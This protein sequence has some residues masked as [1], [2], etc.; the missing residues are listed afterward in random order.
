MRH[1]HRTI[2]LFAVVLL[3][4]AGIIQA[5]AV[6]NEEG[7]PLP[8][9]VAGYWGAA[10][11]NHLRW[12]TIMARAFSTTDSIWLNGHLVNEASGRIHFHLRGPIIARLTDA[13][14]TEV[15]ASLTLPD[16][17]PYLAVDATPVP[18]AD[19]CTFRVDLRAVF[20]KL[21]PGTYTF[22]MTI[23]AAGYTMEG[24]E[25]YAPAE[26]VSAVVTFDV[27]AI[28]LEELARKFG[29]AYLM[30][31]RLDAPDAFAAGKQHM[32]IFTNNMT[33]DVLVPYTREEKAADG[34]PF[35]VADLT[36]D[37]C[38]VCSELVP[39]DWY[40][41]PIAHPTALY[42]AVSPGGT[43]RLL[44]PDWQINGDGAYKYELR[45]YSPTKDDTENK[46]P[47]YRFQA[48]SKIFVV[49]N[50]AAATKPSVK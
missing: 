45:L 9:G 2:A 38:G 6:E 48:W 21:K 49:A 31:D 19:A 42:K 17:L 14:K 11:A 43:L 5:L 40:R 32:A 25:G 41:L 15:Q 34:E 37:R 16:S 46:K 29:R 8:P 47:Q 3:F 12:A 36:L 22:Q 44:L 23:P 24:T 4:S 33:Q 26:L 1:T 13:A 39:E 30:I 50:T 28:D 18:N 7:M 27:E 10:T 20:G 35:L